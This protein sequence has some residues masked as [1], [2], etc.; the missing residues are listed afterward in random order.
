MGKTWPQQQPSCHQKGNLRQT[1]IGEKTAG[2]REDP[3]AGDE[4]ALGEPTKSS[5]N[6][7]HCPNSCKIRAMQWSCQREGGM[8]FSAS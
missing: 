3:G 8:A 6:W 1:D 2:G 7:R 5:G 4:E